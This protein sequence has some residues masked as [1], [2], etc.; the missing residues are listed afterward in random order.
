MPMNNDQLFDGL[1]RHTADLHRNMI[2]IVRPEIANRIIEHDKRADVLA[3]NIQLMF[4]QK[5]AQFKADLLKVLLPEIKKQCEAILRAA[6][7]MQGLDSREIVDMLW[8]RLEPYVA[9]SSSL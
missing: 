1:A 8:E 6:P 3:S 2:D 4:D 5:F 9:G 7:V